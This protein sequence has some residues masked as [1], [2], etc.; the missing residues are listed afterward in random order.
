M[1][2]VK[3]E[4]KRAA[5]ARRQA[6]RRAPRRTPRAWIAGSVGAVCVGLVAA[7]WILWPTEWIAAQEQV[8]IDETMVASASMGLTVERV[9]VEGRHDTP[10]ELLISTIEVTA[11]D[12]ILAVDPE[13]LRLRLEDLPWIHSATVERRLP[14]EIRLTIV[15]REPIALW[16]RDGRYHL[17]DRYGDSLP[18]T[19]TGKYTGMIVLTGEDAPAQAQALL[20]LLALEPEL[21][22]RVV[23]AQRVGARR[24]NLQFD[25]GVDVRLPEEEPAAA[26][27]AL[28]AM[29]REQGLIDRDLVMIDMRVPDRLIV[30]L[31]PAAA[32]LRRTPGDDT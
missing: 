25:N 6:V 26:W 2:R 16:Q 8:L 21:A 4:Q 12:P 24:W 14:G 9:M 32:E 31:S 1:R 10:P 28:A 20:D 30:R 22:T 17:I 29:E 3:K 7:A 19:E 13:A 5:D 15:E 27:H 11:G 18:I 23:A